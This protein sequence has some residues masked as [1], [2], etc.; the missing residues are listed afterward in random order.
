MAEV[1]TTRRWWE[2]PLAKRAGDALAEQARIARASVDIARDN[3]R[4]SIKN[5]N[6]LADVA[7]QIVSKLK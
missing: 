1:I 4:D 6:D 5:A 2:L 7:H 3:L